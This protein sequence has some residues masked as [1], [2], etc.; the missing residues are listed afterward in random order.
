MSVVDDVRKVIQDFLAPE[1]RAVSARLE[2]IEAI[3]KS[4]HEEL[5]ARLDA[6]QATT[7]A[8]IETISAKIDA[9]RE[10][11]GVERRLSSLEGMNRFYE[12]KEAK[13]IHAAVEEVFQQERT[14][15]HKAERTEPHK[16]R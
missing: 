3:S 14:E 6:H 9:A 8:K 10:A 1:L 15:P 13:Q 11:I 16:A 7:T 4:R 2:A 5:L 12:A